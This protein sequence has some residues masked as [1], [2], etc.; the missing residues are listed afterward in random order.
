MVKN[1]LAI[2][3]MWVQ[4]LGQEDPVEKEIAIHC[5]I[6]CLG[7][8]MDKG[9]WRATVHGVAKNQIRLSDWTAKAAFRCIYVFR[10]IYC[11]FFIHSPVKEL[12]G[13]FHVLATE[14]SSAM[15]IG[16]LV[17]FWTRA[18]IFSRYMPRSGTAGSYDSSM[19]SFLRKLY[20]VFH[21]GGG[22]VAQ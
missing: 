8:P 9:A 1:L 17:S 19:F 20:T 6:S 10:C 7:N 16:V 5:R 21:N 13:C 15:N 12:L 2:Q 18:F 11:I 3:E 22:L 14:N 4:F